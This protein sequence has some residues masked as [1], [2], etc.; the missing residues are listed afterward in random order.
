MCNPSCITTWPW[1]LLFR[2]NDFVKTQSET[3]TACNGTGFASVS[4]PDQPS[5]KL[6]LARNPPGLGSVLN[7]NSTC[8]PPCRHPWPKR[9]VCLQVSLILP[10]DECITN[11]VTLITGAAAGIGTKRRFCIKRHRLA[12]VDRRVDRLTTLASAIVAVDLKH[13]DACDKIAHQHQDS[14][15]DRH[16]DGHVKSNSPRIAPPMDRGSEKRIV[17]R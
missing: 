15:H 13:P 9:H 4:Q 17:S 2:R 5:R 6:F 10:N 12:L 14:D 3:R 11:R 8:K 16:R 7:R 1:S